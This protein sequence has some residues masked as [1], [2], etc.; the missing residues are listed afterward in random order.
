MVKHDLIDASILLSFHDV[1][2]HAPFTGLKQVNCECNDERDAVEKVQWYADRCELCYD[3][4]MFKVLVPASE[5]LLGVKH[6]VEAVI[7][8]E[9]E[10]IDVLDVFDDDD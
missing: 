4:S 7:V 9:R 8:A 10:E 2:H 1:K 6:L 5:L 3:V